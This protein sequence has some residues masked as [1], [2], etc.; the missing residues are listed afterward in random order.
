MNT[1]LIGVGKMGLSHL[2]IARQT[3]GINLIAFAEKSGF[4]CK[5]IAKATGISAYSNYKKMV[6]TE[7][8]DAVI[9]CVPNWLHAEVAMFCVSRG[10]NFFIEKPFTLDYET[11]KNIAEEAQKENLFGQVGYVNRANLL[12]EKARELI[13]S[14]AIGEVYSYSCEMT[15]GVV[16]KECDSG[17]RNDYK[18][19]GGVF[20]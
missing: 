16:L 9:I 4:L 10:I 3:K 1:G 8:L 5:S 2:A 17:W 13:E 15:G 11:S 6:E 19:G 18:Y 7:N 12:F 20:V 14:K